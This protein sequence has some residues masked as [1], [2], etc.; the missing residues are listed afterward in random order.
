M[1]LILIGMMG[2][3]KTTV[4]R[5]LARRLNMRFVDLD[6]VIEMK[7]GKSV[8]QIF[9][10]DG[11]AAFREWETR[12]LQELTNEQN[13]VLS[14]GGG[15][16]M[17]A[18]NF[19]MLKKIGKIVFLEASAKTVR[20][21]VERKRAKRP[22]LRQNRNDTIERLLAE[23]IEVYKKADW[24]VNVDEKSVPAIVRQIETL[25]YENLS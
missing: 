4:G 6:R 5:A 3:G 18:Q 10:T 11:E 25:M 1:S 16:P 22:L 20:E 19:E 9:E 2:S 17:R 13:I 12:A 8:A 7:T 23:R 14:V 24:V 15:A 21:R